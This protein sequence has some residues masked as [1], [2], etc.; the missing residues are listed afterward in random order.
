M[1]ARSDAKSG[2]ARRNRPRRGALALG[3]WALC[4]CGMEPATPGARNATLLPLDTVLLKPQSA[5]SL[6]ISEGDEAPVLELTGGRLPLGLELGDGVIKGV[7]SRPGEHRRFEI[8]ARDTEGT[9]RDRR[10]YMLAVGVEGGLATMTE[11]V[12][13]NGDAV[14]VDRSF[15]RHATESFLFDP[16]LRLAWPLEASTSAQGIGLASPGGSLQLLVY[17]LGWH[18]GWLIPNT[19]LDERSDTLVQLVWAAEE[20]ADF[21]LQLVPEA[22]LDLPAVDAEAPVLER[23]GLWLARRA[24]ASQQEP[25]AEALSLS[26]DLPP[27]RYAL[28][29]VRTGGDAS[30][31]ELW[32]SVRRRF[33]EL[34]VDERFIAFVPDA[35]SGSLASDLTE[36]RQ[37]WRAL[38]H[39][40]VVDGGVV[41]WDAPVQ[42]RLFPPDVPR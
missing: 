32:L 30:V 39:F 12:E 15:T 28:V 10:V 1:D 38:G 34:S 4:A 35:S 24:I 5:V 29:A 9:P 37:S 11:G 40:T 21:D 6:R 41:S 16:T 8:I 2:E 3:L 7:P 27:G 36:R 33:G 20:S 31:A 14:H 26:S 19:S 13:H 42:G 22:T 17:G 23:E 25:G 18:N